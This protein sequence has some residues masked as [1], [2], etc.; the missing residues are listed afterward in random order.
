LIK[1][2]EDI[3]GDMKFGAKTLAVRIGRKNT[4]LVSILPALTIIAY[5]FYVR[6]SINE[7]T[8]WLLHL[9]VS[10]PL[11]LFF[12]LLLEKIEEKRLH[13]I[14]NFMKLDMLIL[15]IILWVGK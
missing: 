8:F 12:V 3:E 4:I 11:I 9:L 5:T 1:D 14:S 15:L 6:S 10:L 2:A 13:R 7:L